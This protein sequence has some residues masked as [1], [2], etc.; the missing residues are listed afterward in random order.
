MEEHSMDCLFCKIVSGEL[1]CE[2]IYQ[3][4]QVIAF[5]DINPQAPHHVLIIPK[6]HITTIND[7]S[8]KDTLL[9]GQMTQVAKKIAHDLGVDEKG[10]RLVFNCNDHGGQEVHH[11]HLH[12]LAGRQ[13]RWPPG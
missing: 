3:D 8:D 9:L 11:I 1:P 10:Y 2:I 12:L 4:D 5:N 7:I 6:K 13:M